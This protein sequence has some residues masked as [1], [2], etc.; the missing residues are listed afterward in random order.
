MYWLVLILSGVLEAVW[1]TALSRSEGFTRVA[2]TI[3]F[4]VS[5]AASMAG[6]AYAMLG[7][8]IGTAY[9]VWVGIGA[10]LTTGYAMWAGQE[11][12]S[13]LR[14]LLLAGIVGCVLGLELTH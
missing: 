12:V 14:V 6:L 3:V 1:A 11:P 10:V 7:L 2:P 4:A 13:A 9:A 8:P 5:L